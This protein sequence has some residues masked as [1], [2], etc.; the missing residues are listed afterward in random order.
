MLNGYAAG[1]N[2][3]VA[4]DVRGPVGTN[5]SIL[6][7]LGLPA[8]RS[9]R[10]W[11]DAVLAILELSDSERA[12]L[13]SR[14]RQRVSAQYSYEAW[15]TRWQEAVGLSEGSSTAPLAGGEAR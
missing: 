9:P 13:G 6:A 11:V 5:A 14:A 8:A 10:D 3:N 15:M 1:H 4:C 2:H 7:V 12:R